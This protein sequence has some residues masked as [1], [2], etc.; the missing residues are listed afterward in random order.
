M[1]FVVISDTHLGDKD[2]GLVVKNKN[3]D[4]YELGEFYK[5]FHEV[6]KESKANCDYM[7]LLGDTFDFAIEGYSDAYEAGTVFLNKIVDDGFV[8]KG[9]IYIPG[10]H[11]FNLWPLIE[12]EANVINR[13]K[14]GQKVRKFQNSLP[15]VIDARSGDAKFSLYG[16]KPNE[17]NGNYEYGGMYLDNLI[18]KEGIIFNIA[19][20]NLYLFTK[21]ET[22]LFT[23]GHYL[24]TYWSLLSDYGGELTKEINKNESS[25]FISLDVNNM[26]EL[27][28]INFPL[29]QLASSG[30][31]QSGKLGKIVNKVEHNLKDNKI[32]RVKIYITNLIRLLENSILKNWPGFLRKL[33][34]KIIKDKF[35]ETITEVFNNY[36]TPRNNKAFLKENIKRLETFYNLTVKELKSLKFSDDENRYLEYQLEKKYIEPNKIIYGHT[37][38][39]RGCDESEIIKI[40]NKKIYTY[41][42]GGWLSKDKKNWRG[43]EIFFI[44]EKGELSSK[45]VKKNSNT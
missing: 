15:A 23:H 38:V 34:F 37:H 26:S 39:P 25:D 20:P 41:N 11:D 12:Y 3:E 19:Y 21:K 1:N 4:K 30:V 43:A 7:I 16:V 9:F 31:G 32:G 29:N 24:D 28:D 36:K 40:N 2:C 10:N 6:M 22:I 17:N 14:D 18:D 44:N 8:K 35:I 27:V 5:Y 13:L 45:R 33:A 42:L